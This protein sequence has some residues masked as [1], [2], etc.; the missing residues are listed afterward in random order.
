M[1]DVSG[2]EPFAVTS[3]TTAGVNIVRPVGVL[4]M[5]T[6]P[7][8]SDAVREAFDRRPAA[9]AVDLSGLSFIDSS[10]LN[11]LVRAARESNATGIPLTVVP[12]KPEVQRPIEICGLN[13]MLSFAAHAP[14]RRR[15]AP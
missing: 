14:H 6:A 7:Q 11:V 2:P 8:F 5:F 13:R 1:V 12:G 4:D 10:G 15:A 9:V 3:T